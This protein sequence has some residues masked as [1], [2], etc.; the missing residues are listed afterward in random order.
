MMNQ[1]E[2]TAAE[3][4]ERDELEIFDL[5]DSEVAEVYGAMHATTLG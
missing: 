1:I 5:N 3:T 4:V 2:M